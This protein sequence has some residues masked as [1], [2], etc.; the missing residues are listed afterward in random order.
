MA[1][2]NHFAE[3]RADRPV[4]AELLILC[5]HAVSPSWESFLAVEP[6]RLRSQIQRLLRRGYRAKTL[7]GALADPAGGPTFVVTFDD[8]YRSILDLGLPLLSSLGV[9]GTVFVPTDL[10]DEAG[11]F[12]YMSEDHLPSDE[13]ELRCMSWAQVRELAAAG[14]EVGSHTC[15]HPHLP[16]LDDHRLDSELR[17]SREVCEEQLQ[18]PCETIAYPYGSHDAR[19][20][21]AAERAGYRLAVTLE[22]RLLEP[23]AGRGLLDLPREGIFRET[24]WPKYL[25]NTSRTVR[26]IRLSSWYDRFAFGRLRSPTP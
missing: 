25:A 16:Q 24:G 11:L 5:Y 1:S 10:T 19:V 26:R 4:S 14:W 2:G 6:G 13:E 8:G 20:I 7:S 23:I 17:G 22:S 18:A 12:R 3:E 9:P 15:T 21:A